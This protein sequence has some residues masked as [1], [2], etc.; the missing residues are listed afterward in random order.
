M[1]NKDRNEKREKEVR[2]DLI[3]IDETKPTRTEENIESSSSSTINSN[4]SKKYSRR[5]EPFSDGHE[6][7]TTPG[8]G[9]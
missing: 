3:D 4:F 6:P 8:T 1:E 2:N 7:G 5:H 9:F